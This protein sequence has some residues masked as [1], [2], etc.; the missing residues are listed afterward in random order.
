MVPATLANT[1]AVVFFPGYR[2]WMIFR[3]R[4]GDY[5]SVVQRIVI[6]DVSL[7]EPVHCECRIA[8]C[9]CQLVHETLLL[10]RNDQ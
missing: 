4:F 10:Q 6:I 2:D 7:I 3:A 9:C 1:A 8:D 5:E